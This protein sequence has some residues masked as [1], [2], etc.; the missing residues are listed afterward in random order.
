MNVKKLIGFRPSGH[1]EKRDR[2]EG[3]LTYT[4]FKNIFFQTE[5][6]WVQI[7]S[8]PHSFTQWFL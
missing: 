8:V 2:H 1:I 3:Q 7:A 4:P 6:L 5:F